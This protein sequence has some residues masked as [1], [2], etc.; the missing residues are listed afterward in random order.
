VHISPGT[1]KFKK[2]N[3]FLFESLIKT[4]AGTA[5]GK[6]LTRLLREAKIAVKRSDK[7]EVRKSV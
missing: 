2:Y 7:K 1:K 5:G 3:G 4:I 6:N